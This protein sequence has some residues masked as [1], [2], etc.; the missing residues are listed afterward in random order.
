MAQRI[1]LKLGDSEIE[2]QGDTKIIEKELKQ[3]LELIRR[4]FEPMRPTDLPT[5]I[6]AAAKL[7]PSKS[8][9]PAEYFRQ[10]APKGGTETLLVLGKYLEECRSHSEFSPADINKLAREA[11][12][13]ELHP[14]YFSSA[15]KQGLLRAVGRGKFALTLS[16]EDTV[17]AMHPAKPS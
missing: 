17:A 7:P 6:V 15:V 2:L 5:K 13:K 8:L 1:R 11:K 14:Q 12:L 16:G 4:P 9:T 10:K 3:F